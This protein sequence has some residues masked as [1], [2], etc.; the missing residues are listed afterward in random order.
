[1]SILDKVKAYVTGASIA[2]ASYTPKT[3]YKGS[4]PKATVKNGSKGSDVTAVQ[5]FLNW[6]INANLIVDAV[7]GRKTVAAI[8]AFQKQSKIT[9]DGV[10]GPKTKTA[11]QALINKHK[12]KP[13]PPKTKQDK[14]CDWAKSIASSGK[15]KYKKWTKNEK[16]HQC[17]ICHPGSGNGWNCIGFS[18]ASWRHGGGL[19]STCNCGVVADSE[20]EKM[21]KAKTD[22]DALKIA[23]KCIGISDIK[24]VRNGG[25]AIPQSKLQKGDIVSYYS[26]SKYYHTM[27]Y[28]GNGKMAESTSTK[29]PNIGYGRK[30]PTVKLAIRYTGK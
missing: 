30:C 17:P 8:K 12:K 5:T 10:F 20:W 19:K 9:V 4:L 27:L 29:K 2:G 3:E 21:L 7:A 1:M 24:V 25:K 6:A 28:V 18:F 13:T 23:K 26:G 16:T 22:A 15:Y 14:M 11:A